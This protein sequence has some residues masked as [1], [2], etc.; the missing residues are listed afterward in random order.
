MAVPVRSSPGLEAAGR[1]FPLEAK[2]IEE[3]IL[4]NEGFGGL[5]DDL[6]VAEAALILAGRLPDGVREE[7]ETEYRGLVE[8][9]VERDQIGPRF[10]QDRSYLDGE[11]DAPDMSKSVW[12][13][14][15]LQSPSEGCQ[16]C[17]G[18][19]AQR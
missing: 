18:H 1:R 15:L 2:L 10:N 7:R 11:A 12:P 19:R 3:L 9:S 17:G 6:A 5:C 16:D 13:F 14:R 8:S 4:H